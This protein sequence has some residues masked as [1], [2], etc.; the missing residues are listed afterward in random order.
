M[1]TMIKFKLWHV[2]TLILLI[3]GNL[4]LIALPALAQTASLSLSP[5][6]G[7][8]NQG[9]TFSVEIKVD[10]GGNQTDGTDAIL[11]YDPTRFTATDIRNGTVYQ[12]YPQSNIFDSEGKIAIAGV[13]S[14]SLPF[15]GVGTLATID[16][17]VTDTAPTGV[18]QIKFDF[19]PNDKE[20]TSDSNI[21]DRATTSDILS[22]V[23]SGSYTVGTGACSKA[24]KPVGGVTDTDKVA[25]TLPQSG[26]FE[27]TLALAVVGSVL[28]LIGILGLLLL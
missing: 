24:V 1:K 28:I 10:T 21:V 18:S 12:S 17:K 3:T 4:S 14:V 11:F 20:K 5:A 19:D 13:A 25:P 22:K 2:L 23:S 27:N 7:T 15:Q 9:C 26:A 16:F 6:S 8:F